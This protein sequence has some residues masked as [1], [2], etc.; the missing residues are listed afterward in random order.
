MIWPEFRLHSIIFAARSL[1]CLLVIWVEQKFGYETPFHVANYAI[2]IGTMLLA[3]RA[4][5]LTPSG[6]DVGTGSGTIRDLNAPAP[7][8]FFFSVMQ[9]HATA[10]CLVG[11]STPFFLCDCA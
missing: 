2:V 9:F 4:S 11:V 1:A 8:R 3:S 7:V 10:G 6:T 5:A